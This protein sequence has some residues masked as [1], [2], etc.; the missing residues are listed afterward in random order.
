VERSISHGYFQTKFSRNIN[1]GLGVIIRYRL[2]ITRKRLNLRA[3]SLQYYV[4]GT[5]I[6]IV[7]ARSC[8]A[9]GAVKNLVI[10]AAPSHLK[11][12]L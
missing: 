2:S 5:T 12:S 3:D 10:V 11:E 7:L 1:V 6:G 8:N 9:T 4:N